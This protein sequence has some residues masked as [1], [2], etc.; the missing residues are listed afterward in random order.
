MRILVT[1]GTG[2]IGSYLVRRLVHEGHTVRVL[3][4]DLRGRATRID[5]VADKITLIN[6]DA[7]DVD[8][9]TKAAEGCDVIFH[10]AALNGTENFYKRPKLVLDVGVRSMLAVMDACERAGVRQLIVASSAEAYQTPKA[11][12]TPEETDLIIPDPLN[13]RYSYGASKLISEIITVNYAR[14]NFDRAIIFRPHNVYGADMGWEH[15]IPQFVLRAKEQISK[16]PSGPVPFPMQGDGSQTRAF[17]HVDDLVDGL[18]LLLAK[19]EHLNIYHIGTQDEI[20]IRQLADKV[21]GKFGR[22]AQIEAGE[23]AVGG[24]D[25][26]CPSITKMSRLGYNP[27]ISIDE[28]LERVAQW[29]W[30]NADRQPAH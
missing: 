28:G 12:P 22:Q 6:G 5:D 25:R 20:S 11:V 29:Y 7:R 13:P 10:L 2:F 18:M 19:G 4:N 16:H 24:T 14:E 17:V 3:D 15:V 23:A 8:V 1:G 27:K 9:V 26:R 30:D 21:V